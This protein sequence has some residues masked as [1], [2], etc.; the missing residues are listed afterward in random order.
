MGLRKINTNLTPHEI[1]W[2]FSQEIEKRTGRRPIIGSE[3]TLNILFGNCV[4]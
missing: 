2:I 3:C 1:N 4:N